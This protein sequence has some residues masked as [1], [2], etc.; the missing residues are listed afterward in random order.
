MNKENEDYTKEM[1][2]QGN[3]LC[4]R[5]HEYMIR[6]DE[7]GTKIM[8]IRK[9][10]ILKNDKR[11][12]PAKLD[13]T[14]ANGNQIDEM[15]VNP[16]DYAESRYSYLNNVQ[17][18]K[19][20]KPIIEEKPEEKVDEVAKAIVESK[21]MSD[22]STLKAELAVFKKD[23]DVKEM[24]SFLRENYKYTLPPQVKKIK[25]AKMKAMQAL[26]A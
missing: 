15:W 21:K 26:E 3:I 13:F 22:G 8:M 4:R 18:Y 19:A 1:L 23:S 2:A 7:D 11:F 20:P 5:K 6:E 12:T 16:Y 17:D 24:R 9:D 25:T 14:D 10:N